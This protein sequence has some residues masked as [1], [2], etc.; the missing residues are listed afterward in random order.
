[1]SIEQGQAAPAFTLRNRNREEVTLGSYESKHLVLAFY[2]LA[3][4]GG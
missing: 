1:M 4:T 3:F 2:P